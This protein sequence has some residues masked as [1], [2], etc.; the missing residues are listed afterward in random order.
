MSDHPFFA[1]DDGRYALHV[2]DYGVVLDV[3]RLRR[4]RHELTGE[5]TVRADLAGAKTINGILHASDFNLS[6]SRARQDR[7]KLL[8]QRSAAPDIDWFAALEELCLRVLDAE[9]AGTPMVWLPDVPRPTADPVLRFAG[10]ALPRD[11]P[12]I[13]FGDGGSLKSLLGLWTL[14][15]LAKAGMK[16][17]LADW[18]LTDSDHRE[19]LEQLFGDD[20]PRVAY[21]RCDRPLVAEVDSLR[22]RVRDDGIQYLMCDSVA[23]GCDGPPESAEAA[24]GYMRGLRQIGVGAFCIAHVNKSEDSDKKPFGS[25][26]WHNLARSTWHFKRSEPTADSDTVQVC[27]TQRKHNLGPL[28]LPFAFQVTFGERIVITKIDVA[29]VEDFAPKL[30]LWQRL[31]S[32]LKSKGLQTVYEAATALDADVT[33]INKVVSRD[34]GRTFVR[35]DGPDGVSRVGVKDRGV[36]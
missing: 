10:L 4:E 13:G 21:Q 23:V 28:A 32:H 17:L 35:V 7:A 25:A 2:P 14:G 8:S 6:S 1:G 34:K 27:L 29:T 11:H 19:R 22:R 30:A 20:M 12:T 18:E 16:V 36:A 5:L 3:D 26:F 9:R 33:Y 24:A 31:R 15:H